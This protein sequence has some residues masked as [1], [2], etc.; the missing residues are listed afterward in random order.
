MAFNIDKPNNDDF[1]YIK[2]VSSG[3]I[4]AVS[5]KA[6]GVWE[7]DFYKGLSINELYFY[8]IS[9]NINSITGYNILITSDNEVS[10]QSCLVGVNSDLLVSPIDYIDIY[11]WY[12]LRIERT[13][14]NE[15]YLYIK[16]GDFGNYFTLVSATSG[17]NPV[18]DDNYK[19]CE[20]FVVD[21]DSNDGFGNLKITGLESFNQ[22]NILSAYF[23][24][25]L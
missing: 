23:N 15:F 6:F 20:Y 5:L 22:E 9:D 21:L 12:R 16:G 3:K 19:Y 11:T 7:F 18:E 8:F 14:K 10:L 13:I 2:C 25:T 1:G 17:T 4:S 24:L